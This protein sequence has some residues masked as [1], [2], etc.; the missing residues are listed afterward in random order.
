MNSD[1]ISFWEN[2]IWHN[3]PGLLVVGAGITGASAALAFKEKFPKKNVVLIERGFKPDGASTRNAGFAC[4]GSISEHLADIEVAGE[5]TVFNRIRRRWNGLALLRSRLDDVSIDYART[6]GYEIFT[7][8]GKF[9]KCAN[10]IPFFNRKLAGIAGLENVY[11]ETVF[12][13]YPAILNRVEGA[14]HS[15]KLMWELL[16]KVQANGVRILWNSEAEKVQ[17]GYVR[18]SSGYEFHPEKILIASNGFTSRLCNLDIIPARGMIFVTN[19]IDNLVWK[20][21]F[22]Y[23]EGY[24]YFR[25]AGNRLMI[26][27]A[28]HIAKETETT[29]DTGINPEIREWLI[30]FC[31]EQLRLSAGWSVEREWSGIM[32]FTADK[33]PV[34]REYLPNVWVAAGLSGMGIAIGMQTAFDVIELIQN[35]I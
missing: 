31:N 25:N 24:V 11:K 3:K 16:M 21:T 10:K 23:N 6:G 9:E 33:E 22:H 8:S 34:I 28:R 2:E 20:G 5:A 32:G 17:P 18:L 1:N 35:K 14:L 4:I 27:G 19:P 13:G 26:G 15:G 12:Q 7:D 29:F 30:G